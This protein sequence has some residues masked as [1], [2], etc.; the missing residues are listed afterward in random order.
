MKTYW[1]ILLV[2]VTFVSLV[3]NAQ[4]G[5]CGDPRAQICNP[6]QYANI[7]GNQTV[8]L[9]CTGNTVGNG[10]T[11]SCSACGAGTV[12]NSDHSSCVVQVVQGGCG[13]PRAQVCNPGQYANTSG[14]QL[15]CL[16]CTG[17]T[18]GNGC[19]R[20]CSACGTG[21]VANAGHSSCVNLPGC[22]PRQFSCSPGQY[23][24]TSGNQPQCLACSGNTISDGCT[25]SCSDCGAGKI[26]N[27]D[28]TSC[29][30]CGAGKIANSGQSS[31]SECGAGKIA[32]SDHTSCSEC[33]AGKIANSDHTSCSDCAS[34]KVPNSDHSS[35]VVAWSPHSKPFDLVWD[36]KNLD[37]NNLPLN[38]QWAYQLQNPGQLPDFSS[39]CGSAFSGGNNENTST[40]ANN[41]TSQP[42]KLDVD[43]GEF[44]GVGGL[45]SGVIN[46]HLTWM[47]AT[48]IGSVLWDSWSGDPAWDEP[49]TWWKD[50][51]FNLLLQDP[52]PS[53]K[54][55]GNGYTNLN[56]SNSGLFGIE[57]EFNDSESINNA[58]GPWWNQLR[59][60]DITSSSPTSSTGQMFNNLGGGL[61]GVVTGIIGIDGVHGGYTESHPVFSLALNTQQTVN[62]D[63]TLTENWVYFLQT[64]GNGGGC[65]EAYY[66]WT[67]P[68]NTFYIQLPWPDG[69]TSVQG[70]A[71]QS[72]GWQSG[73]QP[74]TSGLLSQ[75]P[76]FTLIKIQ[77]PSSSYPG[78]DGQFTLVYSFPAD[79]KARD[80]AKGPA[81][82]PGSGQ[83]PASSTPKENEDAFNVTDL[84]ARIA[85][86]AVRAKFIA[87]AKQA[88]APLTTVKP[89]VT[90]GTSIPINFDTPLKVEP[91]PPADSGK[92]TALQTSP[93]TAN[94][95]IHAA[96]K[97]LM[98]TYG[99]QMQAAPPA[100]K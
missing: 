19:T 94:Q 70:T 25:R 71:G 64:Q 74:Q 24:D 63:N 32:N 48:Y 16:A 97:K 61:P 68:N 21:T 11:L 50:G 17:N 77:M 26:A 67:E 54:G 37:Y 18:V 14:N 31:C 79:K 20:S 38:P 35:C 27:S 1:L 33:G 84:A 36:T 44:Q 13:D 8:C 96:I 85:D 89:P 41:C 52:S 39:I 69:A 82:S 80:V 88:L 92:I 55:Y 28:H 57:L 7:S 75:D 3:V 49:D 42:T 98:D 15:V 12:P 91:R 23:V 100:K 4:T 6:G 2:A 10:C 78:T 22:D 93:D 95:K 72:W 34:G 59:N 81:P 76:G 86:P 5:G 66:T 62:P 47:K 30:E 99:S 83:K 43:T 40:L 58:G 51:D 46:G 90:H 73:A 65:S 53:Q 9:A 56:W 29:S 45:C 60:S 87:D